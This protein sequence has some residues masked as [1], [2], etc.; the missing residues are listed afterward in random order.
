MILKKLDTGDVLRNTI[1][2]YPKNSVFIDASGSQYIKSLNLQA[3]EDLNNS[4]LVAG[5]PFNIAGTKLTVDLNFSNA[6]VGQITPIN[7]SLVERYNLSSTRNYDL[8]GRLTSSISLIQI[9]ASSSTT[10]YT[11]STSN[12]GF[13]Q[14]YKI[15]SLKNTLDWNKYLSENFNY[16]NFTSSQVSI[17]NI[18]S[19]FYGNSIKKGSIS[20]NFY[21][22]G[23]LIGSLEDKNLNGEL[24]QTYPVD[25]NYT[26]CAGVALYDEGLLLLTGSW[27]INNSVLD[28]YIY[29][30]N[31]VGGIT[32]A[33]DNPNWTYFAKNLISASNSSSFEINFEGID[34]INTLT[35]FTHAGK[36]EFNNSNNLTFYAHNN[37]TGSNYFTS[38]NVFS[39]NPKT[40]I[41]NT[42]QTPYDTVSGSYR[43]QTFINKI[44][45]YDENKKL[46]AVAKVATPVKKNSDRDYTFKLKLD[47]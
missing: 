6:T 18:P 42:V 39:E 36:N 38:S 2:V 4:S 29:E 13:L 34:F 1:K 8:G 21:V 27:D 46:I 37:L 9:A 23:T 31:S 14:R 22:T 45:I 3:P 33:N 32:T 15:N 19:V 30:S 35:I 47:I 40:L 43:K 11:S 5:I 20:L 24:V 17:I 26:G 7:T 16:S 10:A 28:E 25:T 12:S 41:K 44:G